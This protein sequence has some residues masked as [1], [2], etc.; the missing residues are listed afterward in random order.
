M[1]STGVI[2]LI[3]STVLYR[4]H[5]YSKRVVQLYSTVKDNAGIVVSSHLPHGDAVL[6]AIGEQL[7]RRLLVGPVGV[8]DVGGGRVCPAEEHLLV[9]ATR[10]RESDPHALPGPVCNALW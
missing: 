5:L 9:V 7:V 8:L 2:V 1:L 10:V 3:I 4:T 6:G